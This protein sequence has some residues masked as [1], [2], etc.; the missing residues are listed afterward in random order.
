[1]RCYCEKRGQTIFDG[2]LDPNRSSSSGSKGSGAQFRT[3]TEDEKTRK[4]CQR[5]E[6]K[7]LE[8]RDN[9]A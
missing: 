2:K 8:L 4:D 5:R 1:M 6:V 7:P 3:P 9:G